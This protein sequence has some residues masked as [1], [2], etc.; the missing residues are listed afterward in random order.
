MAT[1][2]QASLLE[3]ARGLLDDVVTLRRR[4]H[5]HPEIG[6]T[7]PRTQRAVLEAI[8][9]LGLEVRTGQATTSVTATLQGEQPGRTILLRA[10]MDALPLR[11]DTGLPFASEVEG[12]MHAWA[13]TLTWRCWS[14]PRGCWRR[15][16][17]RS[18]AESCS[19]S[20]R[21]R[22]VTTAPA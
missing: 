12:A 10:D 3:E 18:P 8:D 6:L 2:T 5:R 17:R 16:G 15:D 11:E 4:I 20:S 7:L 22:R 13:T 21:A 1:T 14:A 19:C 9:G